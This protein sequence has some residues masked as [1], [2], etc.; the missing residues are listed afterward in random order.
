MIQGY[1]SQQRHVTTAGARVRVDAR[2]VR[3]C[4]STVVRK[5]AVEWKALS[6]VVA[7]S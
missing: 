6:R 5:D 4:A 1:D 3:A 2:T 7:R